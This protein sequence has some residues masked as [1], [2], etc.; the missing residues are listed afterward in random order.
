LMCRIINGPAPHGRPLALH[1][2]GNGHLGCVSPSCLYWGDHK[3]NSADKVVHGTSNRGER[4]GKSMLTSDQVQIIRS[5]QGRM[6]Q[7]EIAKL[8][9]VGRGAIKAIHRNQTWKW[10]K[11]VN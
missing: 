9:G 2:C 3:Q 1:K 8:F 11:P 10:L 4:H 6:K 5:L 7:I